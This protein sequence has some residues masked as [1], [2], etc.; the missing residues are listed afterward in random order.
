[1]AVMVIL[2]QTPRGSKIM[3]VSEVTGNM[4]KPLLANHPRIDSVRLM[5]EAL[6]QVVDRSM[7]LNQRTTLF[8]A[9]KALDPLYKE[10]WTFLPPVLSTP[11]RLILKGVA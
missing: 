6:H 8:E 2:K 5:M 3:A 7:K 10:G 9:W 11:A 4:G 1:M